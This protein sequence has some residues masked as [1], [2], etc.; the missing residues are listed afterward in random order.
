MRFQGVGLFVHE[1]A[2]PRAE[3]VR[4]AAYSRRLKRLITST[5]T[6]R[7]G[8]CRNHQPLFGR[9]V[10][11]EDNMSTVNAS[12]VPLHPDLQS[13]L[14]SPSRESLVHR[15]VF[16]E[17]QLI[18]LKPQSL[19]INERAEW[20]VHEGDVKMACRD[21]P[22]AAHTNCTVW[23]SV[24]QVEAFIPVPH[25]DDCV[26]HTFGA[27]DGRGDTL[28]TCMN[29]TFDRNGHHTLHYLAAEDYNAFGPGTKSTTPTFVNETEKQAEASSFLSRLGRKC[30]TKMGKIGGV[31]SLVTLMGR[32]VWFTIASQLA[33]RAIQPKYERREKSQPLTLPNLYIE[34][35]LLPSTR[36]TITAKTDEQLSAIKF[37]TS[38]GVVAG[39]RKGPPKKGEGPKR[40]HGGDTVH[41]VQVDL[42]EEEERALDVWFPDDVDPH[43]QRY[44][45]SE[46]NYIRITYDFR[47]RDLRIGFK[48]IAVKVGKCGAQ[49]VTD[50]LQNNRIV[51]V[52]PRNNSDNDG[53]DDDD[54]PRLAQFRI[55]RGVR[56]NNS[57]Y[58]IAFVDRE[59]QRVRIDP[60]DP[61]LVG[62]VLSFD[63]AEPNLIGS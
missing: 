54:D 36:A 25:K 3:P 38:N 52:E 18:L 41:L 31:S 4:L 35:R 62:E 21:L 7:I 49:P 27:C 28:F 23:I 22:E 63:Q 11:V 42:G 6:V 55:R 44:F 39:I 29:A 33:S 59:A 60:V 19:A 30:M 13:S 24:D 17:M 43:G 32:G 26:N 9:I 51:W 8:K 57:L 50:Y 47:L 40:V 14:L 5:D 20:R 53:D 48:A 15:P 16:M 58:R 45:S 34:S 1:G 10:K 2:M 37:L 56:W 12:S 61:R 46:R